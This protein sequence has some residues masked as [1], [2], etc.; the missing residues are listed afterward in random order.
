MAVNDAFHKTG[1]SVADTGDFIIDG[2]AAGTG[3]AE[4]FE[5]GGDAGADIYRESDPGGDGTYE[6]SVLIDSKTGVWHSQLNQ[7]VVSQSNNHRLRINNTS[8][9]GA[10]Y[11]ATGMEVDD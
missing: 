9:G 4:V 6:V 10:N 1:V 8:G 7:F 2:S 3:A 5:L 11:F